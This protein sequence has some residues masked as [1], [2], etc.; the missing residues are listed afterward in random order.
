MTPAQAGIKEKRMKLTKMILVVCGSAIFLSAVGAQ[1]RVDYRLPPEIQPLAQSIELKLD[2]GVADYSGKTVFNLSIKQDVD[3]IGIY[4]IGLEMSAITLR[5][6]KQQRTLGVTAGE[7]DINWLSDGATIPAGQY[8]LSIDFHGD[9]STDALGL[10]R[11]RFEDNDYLFTQMESMYFRRA[12][13]SFD[14]PAFKIPYTLTVI[15]PA[16]LVV[17]ANTPVAS[18]SSENGWQRVEFMPSKPLS[19]YLVALAVGPLDSAPIEGMS[20]PGRVYVPKGHADKLGYVLKQT[21]II[22]KRL[23]EWFGT[24]YPFRKLDFVGVPEFAFGGMENAGLITYRVEYLTQGD[25]ASGATAAGLLGVIAHEVGHMWFGD[26]VTMEWWNDLWL[27]E[28]FASWIDEVIVSDLYPEFESELKL[29][30]AFAFSI[31]S[32]TSAKAIRKETRTEADVNDGG[33]LPY[34]K[35]LTLLRML[36]NYVGAEKWQ[37]GVRSYLNKYAWGNATE[38]DLWNEISAVS[39][40]DVS[41][42]AGSFLNQPGFP[43]LSVDKSGAVSQTRYLRFGTQAANLQ[44]TIPLNVKYKKNGEIKDVFYLLDKKTG[45]IDLPK[46]A[47]WILPDAGAD[48]YYR[49]QIDKDQFHALVEDIGYLENKEKMALLDNSDALVDARLLSL[50]DYMF[51]LTRLLDDP[52]PL[53][54]LRA[55]N[56]AIAVGNVY[57]DDSNGADFARFVDAELGERYAEIGLETRADD[58]ETV[59]QLRPRLV[60]LLGEYGSDHEMYDAVA[61]KTDV[62]LQSPDAIESNLALELLRVTAINDTGELYEDYVEAYLDSSDVGQRTNILRAIYFQDPDVIRKALDFSISDAVTAGDAARVLQFY[63]DLL[64]DHALL[65][66]WLEKNLKAFEEKIPANNIQELPRIMTGRCSDKNLAL[67]QAFFADRGDKYE[68]SLARQLETVGSCINTRDYN[69]AAFAD[70]LA[71]YN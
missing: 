58:S 49:W 27:N 1:D 3:R 5:G 4:Q 68:A 10:Y 61:K 16:D 21:P 59:L 38:P 12:V 24:D 62:Y 51:V 2:P 50:E 36:E 42:I 69:S 54:L 52:H 60:R 63:A 64:D 37:D 6:A 26:L 15:A 8:E 34:V 40:V 53:V 70:F 32:G 31:D 46:G 55:V 14:E 67:M 57:V 35:G 43:L 18:E 47:D 48:G 30:Q 44:W 41:R 33:Y 11:T 28:S 17:I 13:P 39:G 56:S 22:V 45:V 7:Y 9:Y 29:P 25:H 19:S 20:V 23:E 66:D 65:Y 71:G